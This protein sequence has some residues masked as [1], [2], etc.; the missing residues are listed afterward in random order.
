MTSLLLHFHISRV[1]VSWILNRDFLRRGI[2]QYVI[3]PGSLASGR[4]TSVGATSQRL[5]T[6]R[7]LISIIYQIPATR[8][9]RIHHFWS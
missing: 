2:K 9:C 8:R 6:L 5:T 7:V 4:Q 3:V 1:T